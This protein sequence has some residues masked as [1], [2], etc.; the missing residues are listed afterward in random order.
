MPGVWFAHTHELSKPVVSA[1]APMASI[2]RHM[3]RAS[4]WI[5]RSFG[6]VSVTVAFPQLVL[7]VP[8]VTAGSFPC[9]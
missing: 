7:M 2:G 9:P 6:G 3:R 1:I 5:G 8:L 4:R